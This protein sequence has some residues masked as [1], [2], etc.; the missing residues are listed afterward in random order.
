[1][2]LDV[3]NNVEKNEVRDKKLYK[4]FLEGNGDALNELIGYYRNELIYFIHKYVKDFHAAEDVSQE[5]FVYL[6]KHKDVYNFKYSFRT[7]LYTIAKSRACNY[8]KARK[9]IV[10]IE[11][12]A[13]KTFTEIADVEEEVFKSF[14]SDRVRETIKKLKK[15]YQI[16]IYLIDLNRLSYEETAVIMNKSITQVKALI[17]NAR[18]RLKVFLEQETDEEV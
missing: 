7:Y 11:E 2:E 17:H 3:E 14:E 9:K 4:E 15:E 5:V 13:E 6:L 8:I 16:A 12:N 10:F 18:K 1:M